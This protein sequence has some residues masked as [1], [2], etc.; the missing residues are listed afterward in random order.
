MRPFSDQ[1]RIGQLPLAAVNAATAEPITTFSLASG[2]AGLLGQGQP[3]VHCLAKEHLYPHRPTRR[4]RPPGSGH[5]PS[6]IDL[7]SSWGRGRRI[8]G[9]LHQQ[10]RPIRSV[11]QAVE[12]RG[13]RPGA[14]KMERNLR[15]RRHGQADRERRG[16]KLRD[17]QKNDAISRSLAVKFY[18]TSRREGGQT[19][20]AT[21]DQAPKFK[22]RS[23]RV[24]EGFAWSPFLRPGC[25]C[26]N[27]EPL[28][29]TTKREIDH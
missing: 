22:P 14:L 13:A 23:S 18:K 6:V 12:P 27:R 10:V 20:A 21:P 28:F 29:G 7:V 3:Q 2:P 4:Q 1:V 24:G 9:W 19:D 8:R 25:G 11:P 15:R 26:K 16:E 5:S 17:K